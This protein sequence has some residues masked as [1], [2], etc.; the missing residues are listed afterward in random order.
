MKGTR[1]L[2]ACVFAFI[3]FAGALAAPS[4]KVSLKVGTWEIGNESYRAG[5]VKNGKADA[6]RSW[7]NSAEAVAA[8]IV[9]SGCDVMGLQDLGDVI[10]GRGPRELSLEATL[11]KVAGEGVYRF[12]IPSNKNANYPLDGHLGR[13]CGILW[14]AER[15]ELLDWGISWLS[16]IFDKPGRASDLKYGDGSAAMAWVKLREKASGKVF[17]F[18]SAGTNG[19]S[20]NDKGTPVKYPE[21]N[22]AN[23]A[24]IVKILKNDIVPDGTPS[25]FVL[26]S[27]NALSSDGY[28]ALNSSVWFDVWDR[29]N[30]EGL[31]NEDAVKQVNTMNSEDEKKIQGG[32]PDHIFIDGFKIGSYAVLRGKYPT[33]DGTLHY[34]AL[35]FPVVA[36]LS[37]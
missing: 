21:I 35:H 4:G 34:P 22:T 15:F 37:F 18:A 33:A 24:N 32:R 11:A 5:L 19:A 20:Q 6:Q 28:K 17:V 31:L 30:D 13:A 2:T 8:A 7:E 26:N 27:H 29:L 25:I 12:F 3:G 1:I 10:G 9:D 16:G 23:C 36:E 14:K